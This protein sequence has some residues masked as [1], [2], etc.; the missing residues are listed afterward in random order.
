MPIQSFKDLHVYQ[1][2]YSFALTVM[3]DIVTKLPS[4]ER[5]DLIGQ[6]GRSATSIGSNYCEADDDESRKDFKDKIGICKKEA[7]ETKYWLKM[8]VTTVPE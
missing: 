3:K 1:N 4:S 7:R 8:I 2:A 5:Y 6:L